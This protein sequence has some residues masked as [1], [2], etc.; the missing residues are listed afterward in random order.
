MR[1]RM[2]DQFPFLERFDINQAGRQTNVEAINRE[3]GQSE[4]GQ[5]ERGRDN[6]DTAFESKGGHNLTPY[7]HDPIDDQ[8]QQR[9]ERQ[10]D[11]KEKNGAAREKQFVTVVVV[12]LVHFA[13]RIAISRVGAV[14]DRLRA[15]T[16]RSQRCSRPNPTGGIYILPPLS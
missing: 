15:S 10:Q 12:R 3:R 1:W 7:D 9:V 11:D 14:S 6:D 5:D 8:P 16:I 2:R 4:Q 13:S